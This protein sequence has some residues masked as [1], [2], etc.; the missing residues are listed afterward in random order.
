[1]V[2]Y[3]THA[4][5]TGRSSSLL[6]MTACVT[7]HLRFKLSYQ[8]VNPLKCL[9]C[10]L[11]NSGTPSVPSRKC[12]PSCICPEV[13]CRLIIMVSRKEIQQT[14]GFF[15]TVGCF[16]F[17]IWRNQLKVKRV[18]D[19]VVSWHLPVPAFTT[20]CTAFAVSDASKGLRQSPQMPTMKKGKGQRHRT[21]KSFSYRKLL[22]SSYYTELPLSPGTSIT[23]NS[24]GLSLGMWL[25]PPNSDNKRRQYRLG[26]EVMGEG[27]VLL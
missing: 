6:L 1:M 5:V 18:G 25:L 23:K 4:C 20:L 21:A 10:P 14:K 13:N 3:T 12:S 9:A 27:G 26:W 24:E 15:W 7:F 11:W 22:L 2:F 8:R 19:A 16:L 17:S